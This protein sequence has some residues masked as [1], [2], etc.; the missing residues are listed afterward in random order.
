MRQV[1]VVRVVAVV[2]DD[3][4]AV[5]RTTNMARSLGHRVLAFSSPAVAA[6]V[7]PAH[8]VDVVV[9]FRR[10]EPVDGCELAERIQ[11]VR[12]PRRPAFVL[13]ID[14]TDIFDAGSAF[15]AVLYEDFDRDALRSA[16]ER[17]LL[18][19]ALLLS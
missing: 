5:K 7:L 11:R 1:A 2:S 12:G 3:E 19:R 4:R 16:V 6:D 15:D 13:V 8:P 14:P 17:A 10:M 9:A 18:A